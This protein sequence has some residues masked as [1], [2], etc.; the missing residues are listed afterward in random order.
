MKNPL[1]WLLDLPRQDDPAPHTSVDEIS[2]EEFDADAVMEAEL[3]HRTHRRL[4]IVEAEMPYI[5]RET[6]A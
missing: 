6:S 5:G 1:K 3:R 2:S 4:D